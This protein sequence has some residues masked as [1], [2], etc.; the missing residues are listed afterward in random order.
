MTY[1]SD[2]TLRPPAARIARE[3]SHTPNVRWV[4]PDKGIVFGIATIDES[5]HGGS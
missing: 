5:I 2:L 1:S 4:E 3:W